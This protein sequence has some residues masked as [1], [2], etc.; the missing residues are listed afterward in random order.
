MNDQADQHVLVL[1]IR[2]GDQQGQ[3]GQSDIVDDRGARGVEEPVV[4]VQEVDEKKGSAALVA[5]G[6]GMVLHDEIE[7]VRRLRFDVRVGGFA[8]S[9]LLQVAEDGSQRI[10]ALLSE[11]SACVAPALQ[12][13][14]QAGDALARLLDSGKNAARVDFGFG[15]QAFVVA[16]QPQEGP[17]AAAD[18]V[19]QST[20]GF[21]REVLA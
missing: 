15:E 8:E 19:D 12:V 11:Q 20:A 14:F 13:A 4:A 10:A 1:R 21:E 2:F 3:R 6:E 7:Q 5:V 9:G 18:Q 17:G 16:L